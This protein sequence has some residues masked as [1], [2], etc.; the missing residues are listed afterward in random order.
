MC[1]ADVSQITVMC[2]YG[3]LSVAL[4]FIMRLTLLVWGR[5][6]SLKRYL[7]FDDTGPS[8][9]AIFLLLHVHV[10]AIKLV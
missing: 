8:L 4:D 7:L 2:K 5:V 9:G 3:K 10:Q 1:T 6:S